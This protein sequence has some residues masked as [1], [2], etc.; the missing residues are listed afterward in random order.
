MAIA[1]ELET[2]GMGSPSHAKIV[3]PSKHPKL[4]VSLY[5]LPREKTATASVG[6]TVEPLNARTGLVSSILCQCQGWML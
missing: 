2:T 4:A 1:I 3:P 5:A 6:P